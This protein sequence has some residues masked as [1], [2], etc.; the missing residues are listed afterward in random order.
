M[1]IGMLNVWVVTVLC[2]LVKKEMHGGHHQKEGTA[3]YN[4]TVSIARKQIVEIFREIVEHWP[5]EEATVENDRLN[6]VERREAVTEMSRTVTNIWT[7]RSVRKTI[8]LVEERWLRTYV[9][10]ELES[11][12]E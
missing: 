7:I 12:H 1:S 9:T 3:T 11:M 8:I 5:R 6:S 4:N 10:D 2:C